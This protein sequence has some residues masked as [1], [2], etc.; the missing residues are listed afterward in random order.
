MSARFFSQVSPAKNG[1]LWPFYLREVDTWCTSMHF[2]SLIGTFDTLKV[3]EVFPDAPSL[4][5]SM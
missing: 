5:T 1:R 2:P 4:V 3:I